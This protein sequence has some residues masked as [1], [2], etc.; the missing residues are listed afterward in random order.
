MGALAAVGA[1]ASG[2]APWATTGSRQRSSFALVDVAVEAGVLPDRW[3]PFAPLWLL[4][5]LLAGGV[6]LC[7]GLGRLR[8]QGALMA[9]LGAIVGVG[10]L[11]VVRSPL[12]VEPGAVVGLGTSLALVGL[13]PFPFVSTLRGSQP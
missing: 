3:E 7:A 9:T 5:P 12:G 11:A 8:T 2:L 1:L 10:G 6:V 4:V 13:A